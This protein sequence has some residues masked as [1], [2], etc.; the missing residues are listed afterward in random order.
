MVIS[1]T[2]VYKRKYTDPV[3]HLNVKWFF[4][5]GGRGGTRLVQVAVQKIHE[6]NDNM[7]IQVWGSPRLGN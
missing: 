1:I 6:L 2:F 7:S 5:W 4:F 3:S